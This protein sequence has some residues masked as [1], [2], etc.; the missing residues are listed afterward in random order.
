[1][2]SAKGAKHHH[3]TM[4]MPSGHGGQP[5]RRRRCSFNFLYT[6]FLFELLLYVINFYCS[7]IVTQLLEKI[8]H[9]TLIEKEKVTWTFLGGPKI[10]KERLSFIRMQIIFTINYK[11]YHLM[12]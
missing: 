8:E 11:K 2:A 7:F 10:R 9:P 3:P 5:R 1:M 6:F 4:R 12:C